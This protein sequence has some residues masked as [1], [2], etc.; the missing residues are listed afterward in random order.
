MKNLLNKLTG[1]LKSLS[2]GERIRPVRDWLVLLSCAILILAGCLIWNL[3]LFARVTG[4]EA[5]GSAT[6]TT[7]PA[8]PA[9]DAVQQL[10]QKRS[11]EE[12]RYKGEYRFVDPSL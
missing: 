4:G 5:I 7:T 6:S 8:A 12:A 10:F 2:Y 11:V 9:L 1:F 3:W